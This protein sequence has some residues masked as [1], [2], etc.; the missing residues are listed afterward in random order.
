LGNSLADYQEVLSRQESELKSLRRLYRVIEMTG[1]LRANR[2]RKRLSAVEFVA[3]DCL[4]TRRYR[5][6]LTLSY[7]ALRNYDRAHRLFGQ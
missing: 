4:Q 1:T 6:P 2:F 7:F 3:E 5:I